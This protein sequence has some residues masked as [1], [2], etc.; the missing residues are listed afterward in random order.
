[1]SL[2]LRV[3]WVWTS[4]KYVIKFY[5]TNW[6]G[7]VGL[8]TKMYNVTLFSLFLLKASLMCKIS[9]YSPT[10]RTKNICP[11]LYLSRSFYLVEFRDDRFCWCVSMIQEGK[12]DQL[13]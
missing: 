8:N 12:Y 6:K 4:E 10:E 2:I 7:R 13:L 9:Q 5:V 1:M 3:G 11:I